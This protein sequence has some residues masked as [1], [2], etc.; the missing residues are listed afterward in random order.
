MKRGWP[1][2]WPIHSCSAAQCS[3]GH[4][5]KTTSSNVYLTNCTTAGHFVKVTA[6]GAVTPKVVP[7]PGGVYYL[8]GSATTVN[9]ILTSPGMSGEEVIITY[10]G[11]YYLVEPTPSCAW[12]VGA[13]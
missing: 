13:M 2:P 7:P 9:Y 11:T 12:T 3:G 5:I 6:I 1:K 8:N 4:V 10:T